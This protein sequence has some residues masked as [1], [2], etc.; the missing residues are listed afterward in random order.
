LSLH[1][2]TLLSTVT[3]VKGALINVDY[4]FAF[5]KELNVGGGS[6][7]PLEQRRTSI[8]S[9]RKDWD[10]LVGH[11]EDLL[12]VEPNGLGWDGQVYVCLKLLLDEGGCDDGLWAFGQVLNKIST[13]LMKFLKLSTFTWREWWRYYILDILKKDP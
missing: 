4:C 6:H 10:F 8:D 13:S 12:Q 9:W 2:P 11:P 7:L 5:M 3:L 1:G